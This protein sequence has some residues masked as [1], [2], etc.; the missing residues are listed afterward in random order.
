MPPSK[1]LVLGSSDTVERR[2]EGFE[3]RQFIEGPAS[4]A[5]RLARHLQRDPIITVRNLWHY[6]E[7]RR[8]RFR[9]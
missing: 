9:Y 2:A 4:N 1:V 3:V 6:P 7:D 8:L 5:G